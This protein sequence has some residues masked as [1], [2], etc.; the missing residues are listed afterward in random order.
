VYEEY[1]TAI[2]GKLIAGGVTGD[3]AVQ[4]EHVIFKSVTSDAFNLKIPVGVENAQVGQNYY[5]TIGGI[6]VIALKE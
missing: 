1:V 3:V 5:E 2:K 4:G 6:K